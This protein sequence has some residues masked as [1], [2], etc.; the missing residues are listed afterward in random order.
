MTSSREVVSA[1]GI[2]AKRF[3]AFAYNVKNFQISGGPGWINSDRYD[4]EGKEPES[5]AEELPKL[6]MEERSAK[7]KLMLQSLLADRFALKVTHTT[8]EL[9][10]Y[11]L[12]VAKD[13]PKL[14]AAAPD[15]TYPTA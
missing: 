15:N 4:I 12:I 2:T 5:L 11:A 1:S 10:M 7:L 6:S 8:K 3:I 9:P 13:G 14:H